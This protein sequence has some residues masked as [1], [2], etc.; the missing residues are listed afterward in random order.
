MWS[1]TSIPHYVFMV[2]QL[3]TVTDLYVYDTETAVI[4]AAVLRDELWVCV[5]P[6][7]TRWPVTVNGYQCPCC[8]SKAQCVNFLKEILVAP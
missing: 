6:L 4:L 2:S 1:F 5:S 3:R 8:V 7:V